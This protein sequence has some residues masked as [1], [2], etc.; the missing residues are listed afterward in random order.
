M[1]A[2]T[3]E[4]SRARALE[5]AGYNILNLEHGDVEIDLF[6][7]VPAYPHPQI[8]APVPHD[9][10]EPKLDELA[11]QLYGP[12]HYVF[13]FKGRAAEHAM[14]AG[15]GKR[16]LRVVTHPLF[17]TTQ[18]ALEKVGAKTELA[19]LAGR[20]GSADIDLD[21]LRDRFAQGGVDA[22]LLEPSTNAYGGWPLS[23]SHVQEASELCHSHKAELWLD[24]ARLLANC[25]APAESMLKTARA[26]TACADAFTVP[27]AK[28]LL[29][30]LGA[31]VGFREQA[32]Q[33]A[34][35]A[36]SLGAG[37][38]LEHLEQRVRLGRG[39]E[40][41]ARSPE[42]LAHRAKQLRIMAESLKASNVPF[43]E[44][45]GAH[46]V[47]AEVPSALLEGNYR[48]RALE[49]FLYA[50]TGIRA[51]V[52]PF[53]AMGRPLMRLALTIGHYT[54]ETVATIGPALRRFFDRAKDAPS[55]REDK[56][57]GIHPLFGRFE[58]A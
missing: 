20:P 29:V 7:D 49:G 31:L 51:Q 6:T 10:R 52:L 18:T 5:T 24:C 53:P 14:M 46:A 2:G 41:I 9:A 39:M 23:L 43:V 16:D 34:A 3:T 45:I 40:L 30:P 22:V 15:I 47:Y 11:A 57:K 44:P 26:F 28:E 8:N 33:R 36:Q 50:T 54:D 13:T 58:V 56:D 32:R 38:R 4:I 19:K 1:T 37:T 17:R 27:C 21:W 42:I 25:M 12:F 48:D 55:L 35:F